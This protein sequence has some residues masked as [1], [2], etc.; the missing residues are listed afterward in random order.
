MSVEF[1]VLPEDSGKRLDWVLVKRVDDMTRQKARILTEAGKVRVN[2]RVAVKSHPV[3]G[4]DV[5]VLDE[6]PQRTEFEAEPDPNAPL[7]IAHEDKWLVIA[8][9][10]AGQPTHPLRAGELGTL[11]NALLARYPEMKTVGYG[12]KEPGIVHRLDND[13]SGLVLAARDAATFEALRAAL[14]SGQIDKRYSALCEGWVSAPRTIE[15]PIAPHP[16]DKKR[17]VACVEGRDKPHTARPARTELVRA[18]RIGSMSLVELSAPTALRHQIR[19]HMAAI[20]H[21]LAGD[22]LY[23]GPAVEDLSR[24]FLHAQSLEFDHPGTGKRMKCSCDLP[25]ELSAALLTV[26]KG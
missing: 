6:V 8:N 11:A 1:T 24:H 10:P 26:R 19:V 17:V 20:G 14:K 12:S 23:G 9:K 16:R 13:T 15:M 18:E 25:K 3:E 2:G 21:P 4:G 22:L 7:E 5:V